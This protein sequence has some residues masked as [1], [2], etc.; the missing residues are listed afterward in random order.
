M[1]VNIAAMQLSKCKHLKSYLQIV[2]LSDQL[3]INVQYQQY[4]IKYNIILDSF[5]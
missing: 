3:K 5:L 4:L 2:Q 1:V